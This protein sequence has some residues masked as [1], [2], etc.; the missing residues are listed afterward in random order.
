MSLYLYLFMNRIY[1][2]NNITILK[3]IENKMYINEDQYN[4]LRPVTSQPGVLYVLQKSIKKVLMTSLLSTDFFSHWD[5]HTYLTSNEYSVKDQF[6][7]SN[8]ILQ[9]NSD[10]F[11]A[12]LDIVWLFLNTSLHE[13]INICLNELFDKKQ[14]ANLAFLS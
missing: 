7:F 9:Q 13:T 4:K 3:E 6:I 12:N 8:G 1:E 14:Y 5:S 2:G 11:M 10:Y